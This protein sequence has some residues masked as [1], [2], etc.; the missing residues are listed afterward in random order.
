M[1]ITKRLALQDGERVEGIV[2][3]SFV[4]YAPAIVGGILVI[5]LAF[6]LIAPLLA[7]GRFGAAIFI[8][9]IFV[10][11]LAVLRGCWLWRRNAFVVTNHRIVDIDQRGFFRTAISDIRF[12]QIEDVAIEIHGII[13]TIF[14]L[15]TIRVRGAG[16]HAVLELRAI[17]RP[18]RIQELIGRLRSAAPKTK[19]EHATDLTRMTIEALTQLRARIDVELKLRQPNRGI[20]DD[21]SGISGSDPKFVIRNP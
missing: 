6:F 8:A 9:L 19:A 13:A 14:H 12:E 7:R 4:A 18:E 10:G 16:M 20:T 21:E 3:R 1:S 15:G 5:F 17:P 2:R 11:M